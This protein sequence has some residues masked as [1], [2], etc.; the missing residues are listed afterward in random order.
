MIRGYAP[1]TGRQ[2]TPSIEA[3]WTTEFNDLLQ[4]YNNN[5]KY[6]RNRLTEKCIQLGMK[7][8]QEGEQPSSSV[9]SDSEGIFIPY[10]KLTQTQIEFL[11]SQEGQTALI[12]II[13]MLFLGD[14]SHLAENINRPQQTDTDIVKTNSSTTVEDSKT[15][16]S[17]HTETT[18][19]DN[20]KK[21]DIDDLL[22]MNDMYGGMIHNS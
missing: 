6:S 20:E 12:G 11:K 15:E 10:D 3:T 4:E 19:G 13:K 7:V 9:S 21:T 17:N 5:H 1:G 16:P 18:S 8:L 2:F 14:P 22:K